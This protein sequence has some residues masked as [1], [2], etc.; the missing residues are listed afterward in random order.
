MNLLYFWTF[1]VLTIKSCARH[2]FRDSSMK[3]TESVKTVYS[4]YATFSGRATR[5][6]YWWFVLFLY[7]T[8]LCV[9]LLG[10]ATGIDKPFLALIGIFVALSFIPIVALRVR[11]LHDIGKSGWW[12][13]LGFVPYI[14]EIIL[15]IFSVMGSDGENEYGPD[16][17]DE[18]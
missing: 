2:K 13:F 4:K 12:I 1:K 11:R 3:F 6:E 5:S 7:A 10:V 8:I 15:F 14:G 16:P 17:F 18:N 9:V